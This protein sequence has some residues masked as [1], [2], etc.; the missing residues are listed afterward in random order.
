MP[1]FYF[2]G[3]DDLLDLLGNYHVENI[4]KHFKSIFQGISQVTYN[5]EERI[6]TMQSSDKESVSLIQ[7]SNMNCRI[8]N[9][10]YFN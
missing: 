9:V 2:L 5:S 10:S 1:R 4:Q 6:V 8:K 7:V 3:D